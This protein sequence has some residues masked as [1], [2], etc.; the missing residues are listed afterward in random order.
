[1]N[2]PSILLFQRLAAEG[3]Y[4]EALA[5]ALAILQAIDNHNGRLDGVVADKAFPAASEEDLAV[6]FA[7]R[8]AAAF[9]RLVIEPELKITA[10]MYELLLAQHRWID[11]LFSLSGFRTSDNFLNIIAKDKGD[12]RTTF[13]GLDFL[14]L[15]ILHTMTSFIDVDLDQFWRANPVASAIAFLNYIS[16]R[17]VFS[18]RAFEF[19]EILLQWLPPR[20]SEINLGILTLA[21]L[22]ETYMHCSYAFTSGK[23]AIKRA[24]MQQIRRAC[25]EGGVIEPPTRPS[26]QRD[27]RATI[28][29]IGERLAPGHVIFRTHSVAVR[30]LR[31]RFH[32]VGVFY[33]DP[34]KSPAADLVDEYINV[35]AGDFIGSIQI[36]AA[37]IT[38]RKP[39]LIFYPSI[40]MSAQVIALAAL[41]LAPIQCASYGHMATTMSPAMDYIIFPRD[42]VGA[43]TCFSEKVLALPKRAMPFTPRSRINVRRRPFDGTVRVAIPASVMKLKSSFVRSDGAHRCRRK[44]SRRVS[45]F[46]A[47]GHGASLFCFVANRAAPACRCVRSSA[48]AA[49]CLHGAARPM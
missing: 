46:S 21:R 17:Y 1:M 48:T 23:H 41:R 34:A 3:R 36:I 25:I 33:L 43:A 6:V 42:L 2:Q 12:E 47:S 35:P 27:E 44:S 9:G 40:G 16:S 5:S 19:R 20:L 38:A 13:E 49:R 10:E 8:F 14:K 7:T 15:L 32:V 26:P 11:L 37:E 18:R 24:L 45:F 39:A 28:V 31:E 22:P 29:V 30:S 4:T